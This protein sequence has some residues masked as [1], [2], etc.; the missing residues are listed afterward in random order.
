MK[1][2]RLISSLDETRALGIKI[3]ENVVEGTVITLTGDLGA[4]KT[5]LLRMVCGLI[6]LGSD[7]SL[8]VL[9]MDIKLHAEKVQ[10][11]ISYM[12]QKFGLYEDLTVQENIDLIKNIRE[13]R[14]ILTSVYF[15]IKKLR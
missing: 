11:L 13:T 15:E 6:P 10:G 1:D 5:T 8:R 14:E 2:I 12:P 4:G 3:G 9:D 7:N